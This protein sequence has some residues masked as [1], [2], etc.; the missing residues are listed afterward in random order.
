MSRQRL[1]RL[2]HKVWKLQKHSLKNIQTRQAANADCNCRK[3][4]GR[5][6]IPA[7]GPGPRLRWLNEWNNCAGNAITPRR[8][9]TWTHRSSPLARLWKPSP[10]IVSGRMRYLFPGSNSSTFNIGGTT[11]VSSR[12][13]FALAVQMASM[14][15]DP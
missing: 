13:F 10:L 15:G 6:G 8:I 2:A 9:C 1:W 4:I 14:S 5:S 3:K 12:Y 7:L 11:S